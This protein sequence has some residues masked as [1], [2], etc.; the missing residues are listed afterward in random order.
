MEWVLAQ[1]I[2]IAVG[3]TVAFAIAVFFVFKR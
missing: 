2:T 1:E 3:S